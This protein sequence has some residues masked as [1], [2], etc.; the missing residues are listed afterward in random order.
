MQKRVLQIIGS[1]HQGGSERQAVQLAR[2]LQLDGEFQIF[3]AAL[4]REGILYDEAKEIS[5][6]EIPEFKLNSFYD[7]NFLRQLR[8]CAGF[9]KENKIEIVH[10]HDF[11]TNIFGMTAARLAKV[12][13]RIASKRE[14]FSKTKKQ[15][16]LENQAF[17][18]THKIAANAAKV[19]DFLTANGVQAEKIEVI[20]NGLDL[21]KFALAENLECVEIKKKFGLP[22]DEKLKFISIVAN[23]RSDVKNHPM[24]LRAARKV[25]DRFPHAGF[26][27]AGEGDLTV[28]LKELANQL[29]IGA[30][31][32]FLGRCA[33]VPALL[34]VS[35]I[36]VLS[37]KSEG[38]S[39]S[40]LEYMAAGKPVVATDVGGA[41]E[42]V[43]E[44]ETGFL[45]ESDDVEKMAERLIELLENPGTAEKFG[46]KARQI[47]EEKFSLAAQTEKTKRLY[48]HLSNG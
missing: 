43:I 36:C 25:K 14:T 23:L 46:R 2:A 47:V 48:R 33:D 22:A 37:S 21:E 10:T 24:F 30:E 3:I 45:V 16:F 1:F 12:P 6:A 38:F 20:H 8:R 35:D 7:A 19:K 44:N 42:A 13:A 40:I 41:A 29:N 27:I 5:A 32:F 34:R 11:Y 18:F 28:E 17:R 9:I 26:L 4:S 15:F 31:T 39:N